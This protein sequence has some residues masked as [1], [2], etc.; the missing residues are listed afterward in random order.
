MDNAELKE[1]LLDFTD[2]NTSKVK[3]FVPSIH[4]ASCIWLLEHLDTLNPAIS[5]STV[6]FPRKEVYITFRNDQISLRQLAEMLSA[7]NYIPEI[8]LDQLDKKAGSKTDRN[9]LVKIGIAAFSFFEY[10][11]VQLPGIPA[12]RRFAGARV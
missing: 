10:Y 7:I 6:N 1:Q 8:T 2:G 11:D 4:C 12:W 3:F 9:L 5:Y